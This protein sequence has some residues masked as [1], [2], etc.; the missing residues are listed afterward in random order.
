MP[1]PAE[2]SLSALEPQETTTAKDSVASPDGTEPASPPSSSRAPM[3]PEALERRMNNIVDATVERMAGAEAV[4]QIGYED[5]LKEARNAFPQA[6]IEDVKIPGA[7]VLM[8]AWMVKPPPGTPIRATILALHPWQSNRGFALKQFGFLLRYGYQLFIPDA[9]SNAFIG[10]GD[11]FNA[12]LREDLADLKRVMQYLEE[13]QDVGTIAT[14]GCA[15]GGLKAILVAARHPR[16]RAV[17]SD[18]GT[19]HYGLILVDYMNRMP[20]E[21]R[22]D[23]NLV[24]KFIDKVRARLQNRLGYDIDQ[25]DPR[26][27]VARLNRPL[28]IVHGTDD[29]F[30]PIQVSEEVYRTATKPKAFLRSDNFG[31]CNGMQQDPAKYVPGVLVFLER[32]L[33]R[34]ER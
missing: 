5:V 16:V 13:R 2:S 30:V 1:P 7:G 21:V 11:S 9:R 29:T 28:L 31:H 3:S 4:P 12:Y 34:R 18:A 8:R 20:P 15:W 27:A 22:R 10:N 32:H 23:W 25:F 33:P 19:L 26:D 14:Y 6:Q 24:N 17:I